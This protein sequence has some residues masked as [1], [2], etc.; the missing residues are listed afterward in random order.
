MGIK[1][2]ILI[3][4]ILLIFSC[5]DKTIGL[6]NCYETTYTVYYLNRHIKSY[7]VYTENE[8][9]VCSFGGTNYLFEKDK[10]EE[11][12]SS[13]APIEI[14]EQIKYDK[15]GNYTEVKQNDTR[16]KN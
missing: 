2:I 5:K 6:K 8:T 7:V 16:K 13:T 15:D 9:F 4:S 10:E 11:I 12:F 14:V 3:L 1:K